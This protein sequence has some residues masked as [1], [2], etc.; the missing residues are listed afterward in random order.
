MTFSLVA[1]DPIAG[2]VG[3]AAQSHYPGVGSVVTWAEAGVGAIVTQAFADPAYGARGMALLRSGAGA[4]EAL[5]RLVA[6]DEAPESRQVGFVD[7]A[8]NIATHVG[9]R[10]VPALGESRVPHAVALGNTLDNEAVTNAI[11]HGY[12]RADGDLA[13]RLL[14]GLRAGEVAGG[15]IRGRQSAALRVVSARPTDAPWAAVIRDLRVD[16][17][18]D[19][20][21]ELGRLADLYDAFDV[22]SAVVFDPHGPVLGNREAHDAQTLAA[23]A[24]PLVTVDETLAANPEAA[25]WAAV[26]HARAGRAEHARLL[27]DG[28]AGRNPKLHILFDRLADADILTENDVK[29]VRRR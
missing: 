11:A 24:E 22:L 21:G 19:P 2:Q 5:A 29:A 17:H 4:G 6:D 27:L 12:E 26:I 10:C 13:H 1:Y 23:A 15:D 20:V 8:G 16:D 3:V 14:A 25:F 9:R 28:A 7:A 18:A